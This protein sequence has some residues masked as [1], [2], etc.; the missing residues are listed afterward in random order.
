MTID[1]GEIMMRKRLGRFA[2]CLLMLTGRRD[3][4]GQEYKSMNIEP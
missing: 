3:C 4:S 1:L 2:F